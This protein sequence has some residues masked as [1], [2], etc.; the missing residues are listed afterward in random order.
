MTAIVNASNVSNNA[1][2][3]NFQ[4]HKVTVKAPSNEALFKLIQQATQNKGVQL[5][6]TPRVD[7]G[8][9]PY[10]WIGIRVDIKELNFKLQ[11]T[12]QIMDYILAY[13]KGDE[14]LPEVTDFNPTEK[15]ENAGE[16]LCIHEAKHIHSSE[17]YKDEIAMKEGVSY[18]TK[19][20]T[21]RNGKINYPAAKFESVLSFLLN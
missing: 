6:V 21:Y 15:V 8:G 19:K 13:L 10:Y 2:N 5:I 4:I 14:E 11:V 3:N 18:L 12:E 9:Y 16:W 1:N 17:Y 20:L 7:V